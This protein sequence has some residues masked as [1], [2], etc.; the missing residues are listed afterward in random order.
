MKKALLLVRTIAKWILIGTFW[1][2]LS[3]AAIL[4][5]TIGGVLAW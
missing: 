2:A 1:V 5:G 3:A 4:A